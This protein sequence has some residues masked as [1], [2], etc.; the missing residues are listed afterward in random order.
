MYK[1]NLN[2]NAERA[3]FKNLVE[4]VFEMESYRKELTIEEQQELEHATDNI[5]RAERETAL[6]LLFETIGIESADSS[7]ATELLF[8]LAITEGLQ[9]H[10]DYDDFMETVRKAQEA[11]YELPEEEKI[12][13]TPEHIYNGFGILFTRIRTWEEEHENGNNAGFENDI[14][15]F[16]VSEAQP[17]EVTG[18]MM[19]GLAKMIAQA[20]GIEFETEEEYHNFLK[21]KMD[22][23][24]YLA[25]DSDTVN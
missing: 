7:S 21:G 20:E 16:D 23:E 8:D 1:I 13:L 10:T 24:S 6:N 11:D 9:Y 3:V 17:I 5:Q 18:D 25:V 19:L 15:E 2:N 4:K 14:I 12:L 22:D